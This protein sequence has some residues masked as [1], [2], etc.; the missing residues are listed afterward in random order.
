M[1]IDEL[2]K[3]LLEYEKPSEF[4]ENTKPD[5]TFLELKQLIGVPQNENYHKEGDVWIHT[6]LVLDESAKR[7]GIVRNPFGFMLSALCHDFGKA[8]CT[9]KINGVIHAY[10]HE[11]EGLPLVR[12]FLERL[13]ADTDLMKYVLNMVEFHMMPNIMAHAKSKTKSTNKLFDSV[14]EPFDLIQLAVCDGLGKIPQDNS[15]EEFLL[16]RF[17]R[18]TEIM[19]QPYVTAD[20]LI[21]AGISDRTDEILQYSHKLR[22]AGVD[23]ENTLRQSISYARKVLKI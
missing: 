11:K 4:F 7:R 2:K 14:V 6:M 9:E 16:M 5:D 1:N 20:D 8:V 15:T 12:T 10:N 22:L 21:N 13:S 17:A 18:Y 3:I 19:S 23:K